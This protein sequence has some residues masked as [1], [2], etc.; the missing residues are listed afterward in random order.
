MGEYVAPSINSGEEA[1]QYLERY[2]FP[3][4]NLYPEDNMIDGIAFVGETELGYE[5]HIYKDM[6]DYVTTIAWLVVTPDGRLYDEI[7]E[8][9]IWEL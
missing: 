3:D 1:K 5:M 6:E 8:D 2:L 4:G 7:A 9:W